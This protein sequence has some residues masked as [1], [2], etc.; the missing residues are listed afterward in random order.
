MRLAT[1]CENSSCRRLMSLVEMIH[2]PRIH[3]ADDDTLEIGPVGFVLRQDRCDQRA[4]HWRQG[5]ADNWISQGCARLTAN[6][7]ST[8]TS[9]HLPSPSCVPCSRSPRTH[10]PRACGCR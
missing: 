1:C 7:D 4:L 6:N 9:A 10:C 5:A 2:G 3:V 8:A